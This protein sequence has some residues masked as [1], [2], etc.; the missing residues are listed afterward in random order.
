MAVAKFAH[1]HSGNQFLRHLPLHWNSIMLPPHCG[2]TR[3]IIDEIIL[4]LDS[5][6][7]VLRIG[8]AVS[9]PSHKLAPPIQRDLQGPTAI[10]R[11]ISR[12]AAALQNTGIPGHSCQLLSLVPLRLA[13]IWHVTALLPLHR[14]R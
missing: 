3:L 10:R 7:S 13:N 12:Q 1:S 6:E 9:D 8:I 4:E 2:Q 14:Q 11:P 5:P